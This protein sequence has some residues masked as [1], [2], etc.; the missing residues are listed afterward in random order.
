MV[1]PDIWLHHP[2]FCPERHF[3]QPPQPYFWHGSESQVAPKPVPNEP[4]GGGFAE[5]QPQTRLQ[6]GALVWKY[7]NDA[8]R[9]LIPKP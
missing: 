3:T 6:Y 5:S 2:A 7:G 9:Y 1:K 4:V 8:H